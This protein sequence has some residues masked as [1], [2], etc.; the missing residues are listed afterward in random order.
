MSRSEEKNKAA[1]EALEP[2]AEGQRP[3]VVTIGA[4]LSTLVCAS[5][6]IAWLAGV[7]V[8]GKK[9]PFLQV[10]A[11]SVLTG[12]MAFGMWRAQYWAVLGFQTVLL[13][14]MLAT[15]MGLVIA[16]SAT[17]VIGNL[18]VLTVAGTLFWFMVKGMARIQMPVRRPPD[19]PDP[20][21]D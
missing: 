10:L 15:A 19:D 18:L 3:L 4:T 8:D 12:V 9:P 14:L 7:E 5:I 1:R 21:Q 11:P 20:P 2:L 16:T 6:V 17:Q 13:L